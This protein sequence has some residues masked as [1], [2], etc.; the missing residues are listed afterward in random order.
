MADDDFLK[1]IIDNPENSNLSES[2][3]SSHSFSL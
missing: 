3:F 2:C 1:Q